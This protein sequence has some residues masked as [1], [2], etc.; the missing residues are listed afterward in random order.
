MQIDIV[1]PVPKGSTRG[2]GVTARR[3]RSILEQLGHDVSISN[4]F[5]N[6]VRPATEC[7][8]GIH[9][10]RSSSILKQLKEESPHVRLVVCLSGTDLNRD[11]A[12]DETSDE[13]QR[14]KRALEIADKVILLEPEGI[15]NLRDQRLKE[16]V[17][18]KSHV[19]FQ[20]ALSVN[21]SPEPRSD[22]FEVSVIGHLRTVK[23]PFRAAAAAE[24]LPLESKIQ[25]L[26]FGQALSDEMC[27]R[28]LE[29]D[30][31]S[32]R[33][34]WVGNR[35]HEETMN[36]LARSRATILSSIAEGAPSI[37][38]EAVV[39]GVPVIATRISATI[40]LLGNSYPGF[41]EVGDTD[42]LSEILWRLESE[43]E[44]GDG[45]RGHIEKLKHRFHPDNEKS[46]FKAMLM[47]LS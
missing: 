22:R 6:A 28:A 23:D 40:G 27:E 46:S 5:D 2:N 7:V 33:Y 21:N 34:S 42:A 9:A 41:F 3:W 10:T 14:A 36:Q 24:Q 38:S 43:P 35:S 25:I 32:S 4:S 15:K 18:S 11:L 30:R 19:I 29:L 17:Q 37:I 39:N 13:Y 47:D 45:L 1:S 12:G 31:S 20:S 16:T 26:H 44:F 8:I